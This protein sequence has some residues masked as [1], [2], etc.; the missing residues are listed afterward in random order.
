MGFRGIGFVAVAA[1]VAGP[2]LAER[3]FI[4][5]AAGPA[6]HGATHRTE[7]SLTNAKGARAQTVLASLGR[8][9]GGASAQKVALGG[10]QTRRLSGLAGNGLLELDL[11]KGVEAEA[12]LV[13]ERPGRK[14]QRIGVPVL[15]QVDHMPA[16][17]RAVFLGAEVEDDHRPIS[18]G[19]INLSSRAMRCSASFEDANGKQLFAP[20]SFTV[21]PYS[22]RRSGSF[23]GGKGRADVASLAAVR[24]NQ[25]FWAYSVN[26]QA[27]TGDVKFLYPA[28]EVVLTASTSASKSSVTTQLS[29]FYQIPGQFFVAGPG[30]WAYRYTMYFFPSKTIRKIFTDFDVYHAGWDPAKPGGIHLVMWMQER[31][32]ATLL[33][34][35][36]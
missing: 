11:A 8:E 15:T 23:A 2:A 33:G 28:K 18:V 35:Y 21:A 14:S 22:E 17:T 32:W 7:I 3:A 16:G 30:K 6:G 36:N 10:G 20:A 1:L 4:P 12:T 27:S 29:I 26:E 5:V 25:P 19:A 13:V 9:A 34:Y 31:G 24:C